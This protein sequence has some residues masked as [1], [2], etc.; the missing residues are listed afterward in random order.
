MELF[1]KR[2]NERSLRRIF[3]RHPD[4]EQG[5]FLSDSLR[6]RLLQQLRYFTSTDRYIE[7][8]FIVHNQRDEDYYLR[9]RSMRDLSMRELGYDLTEAI[10]FDTITPKESSFTDVKLFDLVEVIIILSK[11]DKREEVVNRIKEV[12][13]EE[14]DD[15]SVHGFM[16]ISKEN[17]GL[18]SVAPLIKE[19]VLREKIQAYYSQHNIVAPQWESLA[20][21]SA[22]IVQTLFSSPES[23]ND[24]KNFAQDLC[25]KLASSWTTAE[26]REELASLLSETV[27]NAKDLSNQISKIR[28]TDRTTIPVDTPDFYKLIASKN[29]N[30][31]EL[32][33]L[34]LPQNYISEQ[35]PES[36]KEK[37]LE[38]YQVDR[39]SRWVVK[40]KAQGIPDDINPDDIPF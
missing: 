33:I 34:T 19:K 22:E 30:L 18:R 37:Y 2:N 1:S 8:C 29:I 13:R 11:N 12:F 14:G 10:D 5:R 32:A 24:T 28:H 16:I 25:S 26:R 31:A 23:K 7:Q 6:N 15:F 21:I 40:K 9:S 3:Y 39:A 27:K 36:V 35:S 20:R 38:D 17:G 4:V